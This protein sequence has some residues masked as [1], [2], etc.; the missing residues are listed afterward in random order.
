MDNKANPLL[1]KLAQDVKS[2]IRK[3]EQSH[4]SMRFALFLGAG[5]SVSSNILLVGQMIKHFK[6]EI[7]QRYGVSFTSEKEEKEWL[8]TQSWYNKKENEYSIFFEECYDTETKRRSYIES[9]I[10]N[11]EPSFGYM[12]LA[13]LIHYGYFK[14]IITTNFDD[15]IYIASTT[16]TQTRP[17]IYSLGGFA[18]EMTLTSERPRVLKLHG[19]FLY[20]DLKNTSQ[21]IK[22]QDANMKKEVQKVLEEYDGIIVVGY[23]GG[24]KSVVDMLKKIPKGKTL[25]WC[26]RKGG[27]PSQAIQNFVSGAGRHLVEIDGFDE[28]LNFVRQHIG[29]TN[30]QLAD[31]HKSNLDKMTN[32]LFSFEDE[33]TIN[34]IEEIS[35]G[36]EILSYKVHLDQGINNKNHEAIEHYCKK[37]LELDPNDSLAY[38]NL[39]ACIEKD[40]SRYKEAEFYYGNAISL[41][42][43]DPHFQIALANLF[44]KNPERK[45]E[46]EGLFRFIINSFPQI[47]N[48]F[49]SFGAFLSKDK[50]RSKEGEMLTRRAIALDPKNADGYYNLGSIL[51]NFKESHDEAERCFR[52][53]IR[54]NPNHSAAHDNLGLLI[55]E[56]GNND[57]SEAEVL[58]RRA[59]ELDPTSSNAHNNLG[60]VLSLDPSRYKECESSYRK[61]IELNP[62]YVAPYHNLGILLVELD[63][64]DESKEMF[65]AAINISPDHAGASNNLATLLMK[66]KSDFLLARQLFRKAIKSQPDFVEPYFNLGALYSDTL[67]KPWAAEKY[68][69]KVLQLN[70]Q[71]KEAY[72]SL[73]NLKYKNLSHHKEAEDYYRKAITVNPNHMFAYSQLSNLLRIQNRFD[74]LADVLDQAVSNNVVSGMIYLHLL[75]LAKHNNEID[76][77]KEYTEEARQSI[78]K[79][80]WYN[81]ACLEAHDE[82]IDQSLKYLKKALKLYPHL[83]ESAKRDPDL[84][85]LHEDIRFEKIV[86]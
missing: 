64:L 29:I 2:T 52:E 69:C 65:Q 13:N 85:V 80:D 63:R 18:T 72:Y 36:Y 41:N 9:I 48:G 58:H 26:Y 34:F 33:S 43:K 30:K 40:P 78:D 32:L 77:I 38:Y 46:A 83:K 84:D 7:Y 45:N 71:H 3:D 27:L 49:L 10:A 57:L 73:G 53:V 31:N 22:S 4:A 51:V 66:E 39:G 86:K 5:A 44:A 79:N 21:E 74:D 28:A 16:F 55:R 23:S 8:N 60:V 25:Y 68:F 61:A 37:V 70:P 19:D 76:K 6:A 59:I 24:D 62:D 81:L 12:V 14:T 15:L 50:S 67:N 35:R 1:V 47:Q 20:S 56:K 75:A 82:N 11:S 17:V 54:L 42:P